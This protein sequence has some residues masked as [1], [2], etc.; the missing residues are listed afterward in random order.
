MAAKDIDIYVYEDG[1]DL[2]VYPPVIKADGGG[3]D[4]LVFHNRT[5]EDLVFCFAAGSIK[6]TV[7]TFIDV[8]KGAN[9]GGDAVQ[10]MGAGKSDLFPFQVVAYKKGKKAKG[11]SDPILIIE[12]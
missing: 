12:N 5:G 11:N 6:K 10:S 4:K 2:K 3:P 7:K 1:D 9:S 8:D